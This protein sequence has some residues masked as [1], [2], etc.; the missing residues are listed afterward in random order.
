MWQTNNER[1]IIY[2]F[3]EQNDFILP[4]PRFE[5]FRKF[6]LYSLAKIWNE[7]DVNVRLQTNVATFKIEFKKYLLENV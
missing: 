1:D 4:A 2:N 5:G 7:F 6:P 3:R